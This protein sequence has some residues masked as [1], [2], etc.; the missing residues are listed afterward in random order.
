MAF[1]GLDEFCGGVFL[2]LSFV[3]LFYPE[4]KLKLRLSQVGS[5]RLVP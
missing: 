4:K 3:V 2:A 5:L 1:K